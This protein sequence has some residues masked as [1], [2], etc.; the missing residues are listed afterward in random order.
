MFDKQLVLERL[1][2]EAPIL[3]NLRGEI[4][5]NFDEEIEKV[6]IY[7]YYCIKGVKAPDSFEKSI[8]YS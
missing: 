7:A 6:S 8:I 1:L 5:V 3:S 4:E 2:E